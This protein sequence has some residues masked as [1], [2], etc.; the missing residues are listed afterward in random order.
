MDFF[1]ALDMFQLYVVLLVIW[2]CGPTKL[3]VR[4][5]VTAGDY[6]CCFCESLLTFTRR[7]L[8]EQIVPLFTTIGAWFC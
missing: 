7:I 2:F 5:N 4:P 6:Q 3:Y 1:F 8:L